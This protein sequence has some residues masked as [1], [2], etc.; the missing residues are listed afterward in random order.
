M[1][2]TFTWAGGVSERIRSRCLAMS[3]ANK[4]T[5]ILHPLGGCAREVTDLHEKYEHTVHSRPSSQRRGTGEPQRPNSRSDFATSEASAP[6]SES[7]QRAS[8]SWSLSEV[9]PAS[10]M[11]GTEKALES[12][13]GMPKSIT[14]ETNRSSPRVTVCQRACVTGSISNGLKRWSSEQDAECQ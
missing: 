10:S 6:G 7:V 4:E 14:R 2:S 3:L 9:L 13:G 8:T 5:C 1:T 12:D 11:V